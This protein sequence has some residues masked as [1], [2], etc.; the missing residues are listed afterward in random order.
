MIVIHLSRYNNSSLCRHD[1]KTWVEDG[2]MGKCMKNLNVKAMDTR[3]SK[4]RGRFFPFRPEKHLFPRPWKTKNFWYWQ[5]I[6]YPVTEVGIV[7]WSAMI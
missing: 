6:Y 1:H 7:Y 3:D 4:G 5:Y 2:E